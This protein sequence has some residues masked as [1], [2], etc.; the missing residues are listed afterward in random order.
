M[1]LEGSK[2]VRNL[3]SAKIETL[4]YLFFV[5]MQFQEVTQLV[6]GKKYKVIHHFHEYT[7]TYKRSFHYNPIILTFSTKEKEYHHYLFPGDK[8][9]KYYE[10]I[11][12][13]IQETMEERALQLILK[14]IVGD[15]TFTWAEPTVPHLP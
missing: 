12:G 13:R 7:A 4:S 2:E 11:L 9:Y 10:P 6:V 14:S 15:S 8:A 3:G 5:K 1:N